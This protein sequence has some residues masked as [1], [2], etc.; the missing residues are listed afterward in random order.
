MHV[1]VGGIEQDW[2][3]LYLANGVTGLREMAASEASAKRQRRYQEDIAAGRAQ[4]P[5]LISTLSPLD[6]PAIAGATEA[7]AEIA[8]RAALGLA[9]YANRAGKQAGLLNGNPATPRGATIA[10]ANP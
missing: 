1:H 9:C 8:R 2:F 4:G 10:L 5:E 3:P 7:R 6:S